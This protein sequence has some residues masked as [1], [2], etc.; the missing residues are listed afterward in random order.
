MRIIILAIWLLGLHTILIGQTATL[1]GTVRNDK[2]YFVNS[3]HVQVAKTNT[4]TTTNE[5]GFFTL[6]IPANESVKIIISSAEFETHTEFLSLP[7]NTSKDIVVILFTR[8]LE[9]FNTTA[10]DPGTSGMGYYK[11]IGPENIPSPI[12]NIESQLRFSQVGV[13]QN[14]ELSAGYN[15]RGGNFDENLIYLNGIE[16]YRP[17]LARSGQQ[18][19]MS[20]INPY[21]VDN[22]L[23]SAGG[24][25]ARYGD[26]LSSVLDVTYKDP[27]E[28]AATAVTS[29]MGV[30][31]FVQ[32]RPSVR[33]NYLLG[34]RYQTN[35]YLFGALDTK[36]DYKPAFLDLQGMVNY[37]LNENTR[38]TL[39]GTYADNKYRIVPENRETNW[40]S[41][42]EALRFT[43]YYEG[44]EITRFRT[45]MGAVSIENRP[46]DNLRL[47]FTSS[48]FR[49]VESEHFDI[50]GEYRLDELERDLGSDD[51]GDVAFT[52]GVGGFLEHARNDL[53][54]FVAN[55]YHRGVLDWGEDFKNRLQW[56][57]KYQHETTN[58]KI[59]EWY[60]LD[61]ARF[62]A[63][64]PTDSVGY[65]DANAQAYQELNL[66]YSLKSQ[67]SVSSNRL[68]GFVQNRKGWEVKKMYHFVDTLLNQDSLLVLVDTTFETSKYINA[69]IGVRAHYWDFNGQTVFSP[70]ASINYRP[71][72]F[73][74]HNNEM[75][76]RN[77][78]FRLATGFYYQPPFYREIRN[79]QGVINPDIRAQQSIHFV[80]G[81]DYTFFMWDRRFKFTGEAY[82]KHLTNIIPYEIDNVRIRY[83]GE[84]NAKGYATGMD[85]K[86]NGQFVKGIESYASLSFLRTQ[87]DI[88][89]DYYYNYYNSDGDLIVPGYT[90]NSVAVDSEKVEPGYIP[91]PTDQFL[92]FSLFFQDK[93]PEEWD[94]KKIKWSTFKVNLN[95]MFGSRLPY[96]PPGDER[97]NDTIRGS[98]FRRVDIGFSKDIIG[99]K[100]DRTKF[101]EKSILNHID[102]MWISLEVFN[103][104]DIE[105]TTNYN[106]I[107]DVS[108]RK[109]SIPNTLTT[110]R[111]NLKLV[112]QF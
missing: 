69:T 18:E 98:F 77:V 59:S 99:P 102:N 60:M 73:F 5:K 15:V 91:R 82:Y 11:P 84:N 52:R 104:L 58:D 72:L 112:M 7:E 54:A 78:T 2:G 14:N 28:F 56:G 12:P 67:N 89:D 88:L 83:Y 66:S 45:A 3:A 23:F 106:W 37:H 17:F 22:I 16:I 57:V 35:A 108:G 63:P 94:T 24:F 74:R 87:E 46:N 61:S 42:N 92:N 26:K 31:V 4:G 93:M 51:F 90:Y 25:D 97:Y 10:K 55:G 48:I 13:T 71:A 47:Y 110:R 43:V 111:I 29:F 109:Y 96:G 81:T 36:G 100:T 70:R 105:N 8:T 9:T 79:L 76:R 85:F 86:L 65:I 1:T 39:F 40:G 30:N 62:N 38:L 44:Q 68:T 80:F 53:D 21:M 103:L 19:G 34:A 107:T 20:F 27:R 41:I 64:H 101:S 50:L 49:T 6:E 33:F 75:Y 95:L 32:D